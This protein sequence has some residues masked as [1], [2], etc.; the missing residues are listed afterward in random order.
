M[1][2]EWLESAYLVEEGGTLK[3][4]FYF[5]EAIKKTTMKIE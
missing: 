4:K 5:S 2:F 1:N 3:F